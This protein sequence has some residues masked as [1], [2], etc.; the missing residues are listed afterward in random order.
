MKL[1]LF[2]F[3]E[4]TL[5][6]L[7]EKNDILS[8]IGMSL[9]KFFIEKFFN[10]ES[11]LSINHRIKSKVSLKEKIIRNNFFIKYSSPSEA[12]FDL[13]DLVGLRIECRFI[14]DEGDL[15]NLILD[16]F[17]IGEG[18][19]YFKSLENEHIYLKLNESQPQIQKNGFTIYKIDG[20]YKYN[21]EFYHFELQIK[22]LV[23][24]FWGEI[25][26][27]ILYKNYNYMITEDFFR[28]IM[29]SIK[30]NLEMIDRQLMILYNHVNSLDASAEESNRKQIK[31]MLSKIIHDI[32]VNKVREELG[33]LIDFKN[34]TDIIVEYLYM[35]C[36]EKGAYSYGENFIRML[37]RINEIGDSYIDFKEYIHFGRKPE[38]YDSFSKK[39]GE[40]ILSVINLD[41]GWN[42]FFKIIFQIENDDMVEDFK[43]F[44]EYLKKR[45]QD[46]FIYDLFQG[47]FTDDEIDNINEYILDLIAED[48]LNN[49]D[50]DYI[51]EYSF[52]NMKFNLKSILSSINNYNDFEKSKDLLRNRI[53]T[54]SKYKYIVG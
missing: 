38:F 17:N 54:Y 9:E 49:L 18:N 12:L 16:R 10:E 47:N 50:I 24:V 7:D 11:F 26:H 6:L 51:L 21:E 34:T 22:S 52:N 32:Y 4:S 35:K 23:N 42:L 30:D 31:S 36:G 8:E 20:K 5:N 39:V 48:F 46:I 33:F 2:N 40:G 43:L 45:S 25:D 3:V 28:D 1:E 41:F 44:I 53:V 14:K 29:H 19:G 15:Y 37:N 27:R 13:S